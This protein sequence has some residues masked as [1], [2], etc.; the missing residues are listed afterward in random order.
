MCTQM[1]RAER[2]EEGV[3][4][5]TEKKLPLNWE[6]DIFEISRRKRPSESNR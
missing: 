6:E 3:P 5:E 4:K 1:A 2:N